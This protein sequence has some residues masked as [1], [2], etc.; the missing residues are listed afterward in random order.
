MGIVCGGEKELWSTVVNDSKYPKKYSAL[1]PYMT[2][3]RMSNKQVI[4]GNEKVKSNLVVGRAKI[5]FFIRFSQ[6]LNGHQI[7]YLSLIHI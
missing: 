6:V 5:L 7:E 2:R 4:F 3:P 1:Q